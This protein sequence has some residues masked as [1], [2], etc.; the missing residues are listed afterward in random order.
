MDITLQARLST[1]HPMLVVPCACCGNGWYGLIN[2][3]LDQIQDTL[4]NC[5]NS[6]IHISQIKEKY[7]TLRFYYS[8]SK[9]PEDAQSVI[10]H[11]VREG[12]GASGYIC[13]ECGSTVN[14]ATSGVWIRTL[15]E[16]CRER[17]EDYGID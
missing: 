4:R 6:S 17:Q 16:I 9:V 2:R 14:T 1:N 15:C 7:G 8:T 3:M 10:D 13:E 11:I 5:P 12:E